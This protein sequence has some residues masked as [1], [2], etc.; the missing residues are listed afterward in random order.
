MHI[1]ILDYFY[2]L[3]AIIICIGL[4]FERVRSSYF[5]SFSNILTISRQKKFIIFLFAAISISQYF[6]A[7]YF[8]ESRDGLSSIFIIGSVVTGFISFFNFISELWRPR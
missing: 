3:I 4:L 8:R 7:I 6:I 5:K 1:N 2:P